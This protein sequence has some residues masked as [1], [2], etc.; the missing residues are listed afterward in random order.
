MDTTVGLEVRDPSAELVAYTHAMAIIAIASVISVVAGLASLPQLRR[1]PILASPLVA[2]ATIGFTTGPGAAGSLVL[3]GFPNFLQAAS[4]LACIPLIVIPL[5]TIGPL[6]P[7]L[8]L[9]GAMLGIAHNWALLLPVAV[10]AVLVAVVPLRRRRWPSASRPWILMAGLVAAT[11]IG[12]LVAF[13]ILIDESVEAAT[14]SRLVVDGGFISGSRVEMLSPPVVAVILCILAG[15]TVARRHVHDPGGDR[16][17]TAG[18]VVLPFV[19]LVLL[20]I[21]AAVQIAATGTFG[22]YFVKLGTAVQ[23]ASIVLAVATVAVLSTDGSRAA[24]EMTAPTGRRGVL[25]RPALYAA[26]A[27]AAV[28]VLLVYSG[29]VSVSTTGVSLRRSPG[30]EARAA[31]LREIHAPAADAS[32]AAR[33]L[34]LAASVVDPQTQHFLVPSGLDTST[35]AR[36]QNQWLFSLTGQW[37]N[38]A[39]RVVDEIW[40]DAVPIVDRPRSEAEAVRR[41]AAAAP[42]AVIV[43]APE[44]EQQLGRT[45]EAPEAALTTW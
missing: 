33:E 5:R 18:E 39:Y 4:L 3:Y 14:V 23:L 34:L 38:S 15:W 16:A 25:K 19:G 24:S 1:R 9:S 17:R 45:R 22:Y 28:I 31:W 43:V 20:A 26:T 6:A 29:V 21:V 2:L 10:A 32:D 37:S 35:R 13:K 11:V 27:I 40:G 30:Y 44:V 41:L 12:G 8:A 42:D 36:L 7:L